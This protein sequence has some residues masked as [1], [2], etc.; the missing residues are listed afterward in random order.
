ML[1]RTTLALATALGIAFIAGPAEA[2]TNGTADGNASQHRRAGGPRGL[3][4]RHLDLL[5]RH[6]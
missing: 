4:R 2:I 5:L 3:L 6:A 1:R